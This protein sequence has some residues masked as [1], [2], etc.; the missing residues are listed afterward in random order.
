[1]AYQLVCPHCQYRVNSPFVRVGAM[2][3]CA[4]CNKKFRVQESH[5]M[6]SIAPQAKPEYVQAIHKQAESSAL[7]GATSLSGLSDLM[8]REG[9][10]P[11]EPHTETPLPAAQRTPRP[12]AT[13]SPASTPAAH[14]SATAEPVSPSTPR[15]PHEPRKGA[16]LERLRRIRDRRATRVAIIAAVAGAVLTGAILAIVFT[17]TSSRSPG[18]QH[19][20]DEGRADDGG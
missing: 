19:P 14:A 8:Q 17:A 9:A 13:P 18:T 10:P 6:R 7:E 12:A 15:E 16:R 11:R 1:M 5:V 20:T 3:R 4:S 2:V